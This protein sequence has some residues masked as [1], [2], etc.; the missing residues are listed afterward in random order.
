MSFAYIEC[1]QWVSCLISF[2]IG[3]LVVWLCPLAVGW[4]RKWEEEEEER[5]GEE[6]RGEERRGEVRRGEERWGKEKSERQFTQKIGGE[7]RNNER[8]LLV[9]VEYKTR[10]SC[11]ISG[12]VSVHHVS[13]SF[14]YPG[15]KLKYPRYE[16]CHIIYRITNENYLDFCTIT[17]KTEA[18]F[19]KDW[20]DFF[21]I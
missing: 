14:H 8:P 13:T 2:P 5:W 18:I 3:F 19:E 6:R 17:T 7:Q 16:R 15:M 20:F 1:A 11:H 10:C 4:L 21:F 9:M 12:S